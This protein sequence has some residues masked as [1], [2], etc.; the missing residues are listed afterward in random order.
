MRR[1]HARRALLVSALI[2]ATAVVAGGCASTGG[3]PGESTATFPGAREAPGDTLPSGYGSL[4]QD[5]VSV[6]IVSGDIRIRIT[7]L[8]PSIMRLTAPDT[9]SRLAAT[10]ERAGGAQPR[11]TA[12]LVTAY[13]EAP[14]AVF[15]PRDVRLELRGRRLP[16]L[17]VRPISPEWGTGQLRQRT[18][19]SAVY[20]FEGEVRWLEEGPRFEYLDRSS[21]AWQGILP[22]LDVERARVRAWARGGW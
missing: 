15:E 18:Q 13:T 7:P 6:D 12:I 2:P 16:I 10:L 8:A 4:R 20:R 11:T 3:A 5:A 9:E 21:D 19:V 17:D 1:R 22:T 14:A